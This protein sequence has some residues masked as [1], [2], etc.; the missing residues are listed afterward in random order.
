MQVIQMLIRTT[1]SCA[2]IVVVI[3]VSFPPFIM[4]VIPLAWLYSKAM[5]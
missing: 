5:T 1:C 3:G 4:A 2:G